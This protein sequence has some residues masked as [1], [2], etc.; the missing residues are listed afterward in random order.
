MGKHEISMMHA[1]AVRNFASGCVLDGP[2]VADAGVW[3]AAD[4][5]EGAPPSSISC[6]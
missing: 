2:P 4:A 6:A 1:Q 3:S 5:G